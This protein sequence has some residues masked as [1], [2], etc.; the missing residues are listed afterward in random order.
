AGE[1]VATMAMG[2]PGRHSRVV[3]PLYGSSIGYAPVEP[4]NA[5]APGQYDLKQLR[6]LVD[7]LL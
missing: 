5:T 3:A 1:S 2:R 4:E 6:T 7:A